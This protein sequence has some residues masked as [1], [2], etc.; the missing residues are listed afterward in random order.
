MTKEVILLNSTN[1]EQRVLVDIN[2][3]IAHVRFN[4]ADKMNALDN[5]MFEAIV[6]AG[7]ALAQ[8]PDVRAVV[9]SGEGRA[10]CA[11]LDMSSF[12]SMANQ[13]SSQITGSD[14]K[15]TNSRLEKRTHGLANRVQYPSW[16]WREMPVPVIAA[17][18]GVAYGGGCQISI[19]ADMRYAAPGTKFSIMEMKWGLVPDMGATPFLQKL[20]GDDVA[21]ELTYTNRVIL[22]DEAKEIGLVTR[23]C[24]DPVAE[25]L[26]VAAEIAEKNPAAIRASKRIL[27]QAPFQSAADIL[28]SESV[29]QDQII[30]KPNQVEAIMSNLEKRKPNFS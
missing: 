13:D 1:P 24:E 23:V 17:I 28:L 4:R 9:L 2:D 18:H 7:E 8:D 14:K 21:R 5:S 22:A 27:N 12:A 6:E 19:G 10:F 26:S 30:G 25:A 15:K 29:E 16:L 3:H 20:V 11:G